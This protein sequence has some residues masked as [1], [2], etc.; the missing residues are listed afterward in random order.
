[1][2][3]TS[4]GVA[5]LCLNSSC[6]TKT[7]ASGEN[8][9]V[10]YPSYWTHSQTGEANY[11][12]GELGCCANNPANSYKEVNSDGKFS[13][14]CCPADKPYA[15]LGGT[16]IGGGNVYECM[17]YGLN[18]MSVCTHYDGGDSPEECIADV[19]EGGA[20]SGHSSCDAEVNVTEWSCIN[21]HSDGTCYIWKR[22]CLSS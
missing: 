19:G 13:Q 3:C 10:Y 14:L 4:D 12:A 6:Q 8:L 21:Y 17:K 2:C 15:S 9:Y 18:F 20:D 7:C 1:M 22:S 11:E 5:G 16:N